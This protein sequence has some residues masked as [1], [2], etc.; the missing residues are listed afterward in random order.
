VV[1]FHDH[2]S[3]YLA[4]MFNDDWMREKGFLEPTGLTAR[5]LVATKRQAPLVTVDRTETVARTAHVMTE[6]G[7]SQIPITAD[8]RI[9][10]AI[11]ETRLYA[12]I[13]KNPE[14]K[15]GPVEAIMQPAFPFV[16]VSASLESLAEML[17][18]ESPAVLVRDFKSEQTYI[19]TRSDVIQALS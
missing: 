9:V 17:T 2:G 19:I 7:F 12:E 11:S 13:V 3:R 5:D 4:K 1:V 6:R 18:P 14:I 8:G 15:R 10:G 16:D